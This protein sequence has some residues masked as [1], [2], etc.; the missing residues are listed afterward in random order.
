MGEVHHQ[1]CS[2][3]FLVRVVMPVG[4]VLNVGSTGTS[5]N[6]ST[7]NHTT[8]QLTSKSTISTRD[9]YSPDIYDYRQ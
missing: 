6:T 7:L 2:S 8:C 4:V 1:F 3:I 9:E 5:P